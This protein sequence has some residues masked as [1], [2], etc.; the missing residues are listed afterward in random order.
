VLT[1]LTNGLNSL[2]RLYRPCFDSIAR[3]NIT[4][5]ADSGFRPAHAFFM[6]KQRK[7]QSTKNDS[8]GALS[9]NTR[10][11]DVGT[12]S[13]YFSIPLRIAYLPGFPR[14]LVRN[15]IS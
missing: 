12:H 13:L 15:R 4:E 6:V 10:K 3:F 9:E 8:S 7:F 5:N 14:T 2:A 11:A 1:F